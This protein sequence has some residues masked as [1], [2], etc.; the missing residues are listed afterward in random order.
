MVISHNERLM[1]SIFNHEP[2]DTIP[3]FIQSIMEEV[4]LPFEQKY[5]ENFDDNDILLTDIGDLTPFKAF[6][7]SSHWCGAPHVRTEVTSALQEKVA[8]MTAEIQKEDPRLGISIH[9][10]VR[11]SARVMNNKHGIGWHVRGAVTDPVLLDWWLDQVTTSRPAQAEIDRFTRALDQCRNANFVPVASSNLVMEPAPQMTGFGLLGTLMRKEK[12]HPLLRKLFDHF[13]T[14]TM[15]Q[16]EAALKS[17]YHIFVMA[18]DMAYKH[19][20][21]ISP[22]QYETFV[23]PCIREV[24]TLI[25]EHD[26]DGKVFL[27]TDGDIYPMLDIFVDA[28]LDGLNPLEVNSGMSLS[29]VKKTHGN[30]LA[31][32]GN[33]DTAELLPY[34]TEEAVRRQV[35]VI[36]KEG[37]NG[38]IK[39]GHIF[40]PC[41]TL[42][43]AVKMENAV[44]MMDELRKVNDGLVPL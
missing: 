28:G 35:H 22:K 32:I 43:H 4:W 36:L 24:T 38:D 6:G 40:A 39:T 21:M 7:F 3:S 37:M 31:F 42:H 25:H 18:D 2:V 16:F 44:A 23:S 34:G 20:P 14:A 10:A 12:Y 8:A 19:G 29:R 13:T 30:K 9:G 41:G 33:L 11:G 17:G 27:H 26:K 1:L 5:G 15:Y